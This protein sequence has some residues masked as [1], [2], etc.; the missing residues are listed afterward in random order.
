VY[1]RIGEYGVIGNLE[2][3]ALVG[4]DGSIDW[5]CLP[6]LDSPSLFGA[7][8]DAARGG[9][10]AVCP[11][12]KYKAEARY[13]PGTNILQTTFDTA[14]GRT[15]LTDFMPVAAGGSAQG[16]EENT[17][18]SLYRHVEVVSG[19]AEVVLHFEPRFNYAREETTIL[20]KPGGVLARSGAG[21]VTL[22]CTRELQ[23]GGSS[24]LGKWRLEAGEDLWLKME[25]AES[26]DSMPLDLICLCEDQARRLQRETAKF[27]REW[28]QVNET[29][30]EF[31][32]GSFKE[33]IDRSA[34]VLKLLVYNP[35]GAIAAAATTSLPEEIGGERNW[36]YRYTWIRDT[37]LTLR[38]LFDLGHLSEMERYLLWIRDT[39]QGQ[40]AEGMQI[41]YGLRGERN[42]PEQEL[43]HLEGY[44]GSRPVRVGNDAAGQRQLDIYGELLDAA[45]SLS[46][47]VGK[48]DEEAWPFLREVCDYVVGHW[49][50]KDSGIWEVR[51][52]P[53]H[54]VHSKV[55]CWVALD[56]GLS[57]ADRYGFPADTVTW[58][59]TRDRIKAEVLEK[60]FSEQK[61]SF[62]MHY[63]TQALDASALLIPRVGFLPYDDPRVVSTIKAVQE[64]LS[65][66]GLLSRY[67]EKDGLPGTEGRFLLC[68]FWLADCLIHLG[69]LDEAEEL[70]RTIGRAANSLGLF[71]EE[72]DPGSGEQLG[73]FPQAFTHIGCV[74]TVMNLLRAKGMDK[75]V[76]AAPTSPGMG[77]LARLIPFKRTLNSG[78]AASAMPPEHIASELKSVMN[79]LRGAFF[80][81]V[82]GRVAYEKMRTS[83][84]Y[85][86]YVNL[87]YSLR[88]LDPSTLST[89]EAKTAF[90]INLYNVIVIHGVIE[91][92]IHTSIK[93]VRRFLSRAC[94]RIGGL[95][96]TPDDIEHGILRANRRPPHSLFHRFGRHDPR[97]GLALEEVDPR[98]HFAL[99]CAS[100]SCPPIDVYTEERIDRE[101]EASGRT[102]V[103]SRGILIDRDKTRVRLSQVFSWYAE[104]FGRSTAE[105]LRSIAAYLYAEEDRSYL[106]ENAHRLKVDYLEYDWR[107]NR[108]AKG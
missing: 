13:L 32:L 82:Q 50:E 46:D 53:F 102:F 100:S 73:N 5:L 3:A 34:L 4:I 27:W 35:S 84:L 19:Q 20:P 15:V 61:Q 85:R 48:I 49:Q 69:R 10:F 60:G 43:D 95:S 8:L 107:L 101:L 72:Y 12:E 37:S 47:Y 40:G 22:A 87:S 59:R 64:E 77:V 90:W 31:D 56:R 26:P 33:L 42:I 65:D 75:P 23:P 51:G 108:G 66:D 80:D 18:R 36:D 81:T 2:T 78:M 25:L 68:S 105:R 30:K 17:H 97:R 11:R 57:I 24:A 70:M 63:D 98:I 38:A 16:E 39:L 44:R 74:N 7:L 83:E 76:R 41:M 55:M 28:L 91:F 45:R 106:L 89:R 67:K 99:V 29:G 1:K 71:S 6:S 9:R 79:R 103:N 86:K 21:S 94:Y 14:F 52:G 96:F 62:V 93:E 58:E 92:H 88:E 54:F 104:D